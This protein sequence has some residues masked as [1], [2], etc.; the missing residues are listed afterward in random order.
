FNT[1]KE[2][3]GY[4]VSQRKKPNDNATKAIGATRSEELKNLGKGSAKK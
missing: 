2:M 1:V 3:V 4:I